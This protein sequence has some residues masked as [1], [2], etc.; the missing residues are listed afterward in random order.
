MSA[1]FDPMTIAAR[2]P[3]QTVLYDEEGA[4]ERTLDALTEVAEAQAGAP[5]CVLCGQR[6][7]VPDPRGLCSKVSDNH[8]EYRAAPTMT[9]ARKAHRS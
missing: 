6:V 9:T 4:M 2:Q 8:R 1:G 7:N 3:S 5:A